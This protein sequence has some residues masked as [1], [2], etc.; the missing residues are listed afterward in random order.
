MRT[1]LSRRSLLRAGAASV[2]LP[3]LDAML[4]RQARAAESAIPQRMVLLHRGLGTYHPYLVPETTGPDYAAN[5]YLKKFEAHRGDFT[6]FSGVSHRGYPNS[7]TTAA[8]IF[9]GVGPEGVARG[10]DIHN[11][12]SLD[13]VAANAIGDQTRVRS[14]TLNSMGGAPSLSWNHKG[15]PVP[16]NGSRSQ[17]F[18]TLFIDGTPAEIKRQLQRLDHGHS[19]LDNMRDDLRKLRSSV[20]PG[21]RDRLDIMAN[22][23]RE[24]EQLLQQEAA[25]A[26]KPKPVIEVELNALDKGGQHWLEDQERWFVL[27]RLAL[28]TDSTRVIV[29]GLGEHNNRNV[30]DLELGHHDASHHGKDPAK[31]EQFARYEEK[32]YANVAGFLGALRT[33][34][35]VDG[36]LLDSTQVLLTSNLGD[37]SA[38]ASD[39]LPTFLAGGGY[40]HQG[41]LAF[42][43]EDNYPLSNIYLRMAQ[44]MGI[45]ADAF[46]SSTGALSELG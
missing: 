42:D 46:G 24:A 39:N 18:K 10:D 22:S 36:N 29:Y 44:Q 15:V 30:S 1:P 34:P 3:F 38:H 31:I 5:R 7:H 23:I 32:E 9:T 17:V 43:S 40:R 35:E 12:I 14:L 27:L 6:L 20:G 4:P 21:D 8:A 11:T 13:Q 45:N 2:S 25:W 19:I 37:A 16:R 28:Q 26:S 41:H 33:T